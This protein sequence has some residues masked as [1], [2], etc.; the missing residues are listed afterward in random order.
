MGL[1]SF[2]GMDDDRVFGALADRTRRRLL[3]SLQAANGQTLTELC[4]GEAMSRQAVT[5]HLDVLVEAGLV[6]L[7]REGRERRHFL[8]TAPVND[9]ADRWIGRHLERARALADLTTA[10]ETTTMSSTIPTPT[11]PSSD[12][13][14]DSAFVYVA[15]IRTTPQRL[16][17]ALTTPEFIRRYFGGGG[18]H[19][20]WQVGSGVGWQMDGDDDVHDWGQRVLE[21]EAG[22]RLSYTWHSYQPEMQPIFGWSDE[23]LARLQEE[24]LTK[25]TFEID[26]E[27]D[28]V[29][30]LTLTHEGF[31]PGSEMGRAVAGGWPAIVSDLKSLLETGSPV[32]P[33][34]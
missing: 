20:D 11:D 15:Y 22:K 6:V 21:A 25:V 19:S 26:D 23:Q 31:V 8:N 13:S 4:A 24:P 9:I 33:G 18:P 32:T 10:L 28:G 30:R 14:R 34:A 3:D 27:G 12:P 1:P 29:V 16:W 5:K 2:A 7:R 17:E